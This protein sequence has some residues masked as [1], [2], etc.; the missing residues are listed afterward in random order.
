MKKETEKDIM[1]MECIGLMRDSIEKMSEKYP[2]EI[3]NSALIELGLRMSMIQGG[4]YHTIRIFA[5]IM[6]N[7]ATFGQLMERD[8]AESIKA[9][10][11]PDPFDDWEYTATK[12]TIH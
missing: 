5:G 8:I 4:S 9:G 1:F 12:K 6:N 7:I 10:R 2:L 11:D 3:V